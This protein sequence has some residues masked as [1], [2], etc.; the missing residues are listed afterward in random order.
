MPPWFA[1]AR[2]GHFSNERKLTEKETHTLAAWAD[3]GAPEGD[4]KD[5]AAPI[6][7]PEGWSIG[8]PDIVVE[9]PNEFQ[10]PAQGTIEYQYILVKGNFTQ[11]LWVQAAELR[12]TNRQ[13]VHHMK[14]YIRPPGSHFMADAIPGVPVE[15]SRQP[16]PPRTEPPPPDSEMFAGMARKRSWRSTI[17]VSVRR[18][19]RLEMPRNFCR[20]AP[21]SCSRS[22]TQPWVSRPLTDPKS[23]SFWRRTLRSGVTSRPES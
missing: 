16:R 15:L 4:P 19:S 7:F 22:T 2:Y 3:A 23:E 11:D 12:P 8:T 1:D 10:L 21:I 5:R 6:H 9:L 17:R 13:V 20:P 14:A 18:V